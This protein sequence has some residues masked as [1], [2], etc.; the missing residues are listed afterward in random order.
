MHHYGQ[1]M[2]KQNTVKK[3][4]CCFSKCM[5]PIIPMGSISL[6]TI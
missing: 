5:S 6:L 1:H 4:V 3:R 2:S